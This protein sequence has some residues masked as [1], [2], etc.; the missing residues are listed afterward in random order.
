MLTHH[1]DVKNS[2]I[3]ED[4]AAIVEGDVAEIIKLC[5]QEKLPCV[6][7]IK[8]NIPNIQPQGHCGKSSKPLFPQFETIVG[9]GFA[10]TYGYGING[11][12][13]GRSRTTAELQFYVHHEYTR[14]GIGR[15]LLDRLIQSLSHSYAYVAVFTFVTIVADWNI[16]C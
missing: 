4:Q 6:V 14:K 10:Q 7:A 8:G 13:S 12:R 9:F 16:Q 15:S 3:P 11:L 1:V 5:Q 2:I